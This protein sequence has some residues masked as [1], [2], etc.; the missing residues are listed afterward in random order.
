MDRKINGNK[1]KPIG[2]TLCGKLVG[3]SVV[4]YACNGD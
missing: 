3:M 2:I 4:C 1:A